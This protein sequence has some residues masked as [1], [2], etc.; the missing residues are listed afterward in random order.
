MSPNCFQVVQPVPAGGRA[1]SGLGLPA[2][3]ARRGFKHCQRTL[4][5][6]KTQGVPRMRGVGF[7]TIAYDY[8]GVTSSGLAQ[9]D[10]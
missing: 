10:R 6:S 7:V 3:Q 4:S 1:V 2:G 9:S 5:T 8:K